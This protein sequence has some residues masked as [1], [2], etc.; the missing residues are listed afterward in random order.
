VVQIRYLETKKETLAEGIT[1]TYGDYEISITESGRSF[2]LPC[3]SLRGEH[4]G[5]TDRYKQIDCSAEVRDY[6]FSFEY[7]RFLETK[8]IGYVEGH[9]SNDD[10]PSISGGTCT[11]IE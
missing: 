7:K 1:E 11:R 4:V 6:R 5:K 9:D 3:W 10:T 2:A 8:V